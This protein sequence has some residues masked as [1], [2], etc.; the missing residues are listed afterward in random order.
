MPRSISKKSAKHLSYL[1]P[2]LLAT[3]CSTTAHKDN[4]GQS[5]SSKFSVF[6]RHGSTGRLNKI[7]GN[8]NEKENTTIWDRMLSLYALPEIENPRIDREINFY[9]RNPEY[10]SRVQQ[11]AEPYLYFI[12][13]EIEA[14]NIPGELA[15]LPAV[16]SAFRADAQSPAQASGLWQ[17]IPPTGRLYG[18]KQNRWYDGRRDVVESTQAATTFLKQLSEEFN[19]DWFLALASYNAGKGNIKNAI[20]RNLDRGH[21]TDFWSLDLNNETSAYVP[22]LLA[23]AKIFANP[24]KYNVNLRQFANQP[25]F[26]LVDIQSQI[27]LGTAAALAQTPVDDFLKLNPGFNRKS[28]APESDGPSRLLVPVDKAE[29]F[30]EKLAELPEHDHIKWEHHTVGKQET[31]QAIAQKHRTTVDEIVAVNHLGDELV[32]QGKILLI[33]MPSQDNKTD[34]TEVA[35]N[36]SEQNHSAATAKTSTA[37]A[38]KQTYTVKKGD[39]LWNVSQRFSVDKD[40]I[41]SWNKL[42]SKAALKPGQKLTIKKSSGHITVASAA[43]VIKQFSYTVKAGDSLGQI[44]KKFRVDVTDLRKWNNVP[45]N[46]ADLKPGSKLKVMVEHTHSAT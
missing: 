33:P 42:S 2:V 22:R 46:R 45:K 34:E 35:S 38:S 41:L 14:K 40:D 5:S 36:S 39:T 7:E 43:P 3:G 26:E 15:L 9:L 30:K 1:L 31:L 8:D 37:T 6:T 27:D 4:L 23:I 18:L 32:A 17:F 10:L 25:Y 19:N 16:E 21:P 44:A 20:G 12:L 28:T 13:N 11:R 29:T 24:E